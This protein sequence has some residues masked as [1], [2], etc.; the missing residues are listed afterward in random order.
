VCD[1]HIDTPVFEQ[2][3]CDLVSPVPARTLTGV[4]DAGI[5]TVPG[6]SG[7]QEVWAGVVLEPE[8]VEGAEPAVEGEEPAEGAEGEPAP[9]GGEES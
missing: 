9:E 7:Y 6:A 8:I 4:A 3:Q 1:S 2:V 5:C